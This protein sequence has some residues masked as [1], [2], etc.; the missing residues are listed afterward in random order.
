[1]AGRPSRYGRRVGHFAMTNS[2]RTSLASS[3]R[4]LIGCVVLA[5]GA[6]AASAD[7][8][9]APWAPDLGNGKFKN[10]VLFADYSDPD[11][12]RV[13][14][15]YYLTASSFNCVPGLPLLHSRDLV[16]WE[17]IGYAIE[18][19]PERFNSVEF[20]KGIWAP[21]LRYH[22][23]Y[24]WIVVGDPDWGILMTK[25]KDP[26]GPWSPLHV[27][28]EGKGLI[29]PC[30]LWDEDGKAYLVHAFA[31]SRAGKN[32]IIVAQ[33]M[34][35]DGSGVIGEEHLVI[36]GQNNVYPTIEG[37]KFYKRDGWY[38]IMAPAGGVKPGYQIAARSKAPFGPYEVKKVLEQGSTKIN[39][40]HQGGWIDTPKGEDW[41]MHFQD[42]E[43]Y[44]RVV[45]LNPV[46]WVDGW[47]LM[48]KDF[49]G[50][51]VGEPLDTSAKPAIDGKVAIAVPPTSDAFDGP[52]GL[53]WQWQ[54]NPQ[55]GWASLAERKGWL[56]LH[57]VA[58]P[59]NGNLTAAPYQL[60]QKL[61]A[62]EFTATTA[63]E[64]QPSSASRAGDSRAGLVI[65]GQTYA[66][67]MVSAEGDQ[68]KL[69]EITGGKPGSTPPTEPAPEKSVASTTAP[70]GKVWL[71]VAVTQPAVCT[72]SYSTDGKE[73]TPLGK[74]FTATAGYWM[75]S[76]VGLVC[77][78]E[79][80]TAD[81]ESFEIR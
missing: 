31:K 56:R 47:P 37:P 54:G 13:G 50:N 11:V 44:G 9:V 59:T 70:K 58:P 18:R 17:L 61:P 24:Y 69:T 52:L 75:G 49:D 6:P 4:R 36:D 26:K 55:E 7:A 66:G 35:P 53:Q 16:N 34:K 64:F 25:A 77:Q 48:G 1:V 60:L 40:P 5:L 41:F 27:V 8:P 12:I 81:F 22:D 10:P 51:G 63:V 42:V 21:S 14:S 79:G 19:M 33:E 3:L 62:P 20:G 78:G 68:L 43:A 46:T 2:L 72:F 74:P 73:F 15:D 76:K 65:M 30:P 57:G 29:D 80:S 32:S 39:G 23:G 45:H 28:K 38:Y 67:L 71:R